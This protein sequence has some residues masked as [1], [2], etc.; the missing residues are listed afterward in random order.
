MLCRYIV[1]KNALKPVSRRGSVVSSGAE[2]R[3]NYGNAKEVG[4][5]R[6]LRLDA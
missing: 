1:V 6:A 3:K 2:Y 5:V 4:A